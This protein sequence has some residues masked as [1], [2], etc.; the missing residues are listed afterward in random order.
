VIYYKSIN[1]YIQKKYVD[2]KLNF[3]ILN[4]IAVIISY[5]NETKIGKLFVVTIVT[6]STPT[7]FDFAGVIKEHEL[8]I[9]FT[10]QKYAYS[11]FEIPTL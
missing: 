11:I 1:K 5:Y 10:L 6:C 2:W 7:L 9:F 8:C 4:I 3:T